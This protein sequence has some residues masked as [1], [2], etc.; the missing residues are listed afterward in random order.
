MLDVQRFALQ[1]EEDGLPS[2]TALEIAR[3]LALNAAPMRAGFEITA[4]TP[5]SLIGLWQRARAEGARGLTVRL[6]A[7]PDSGGVRI[8]VVAVHHDRL[9]NP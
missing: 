9:G 6:D 2:S 7:A 4:A 3:D 5:A 8:S 1:L